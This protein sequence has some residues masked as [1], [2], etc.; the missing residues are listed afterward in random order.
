[1]FKVFLAEDE[2]V[3]REGL[4]NNIAWE[5]YGFTC[6]G[7]AADGEMALPLIRQLKPDLLITD[8]KMPFMDGLALSAFVRRELPDT[9]IIIISGYDDFKYAQQAISMGVDEYLLKPITRA[10]MAGILASLQK[11]LEDEREMKDYMLKFRQETQEYEQFARRRFF[12]KLVQGKLSAQEIYQGAE[13]LGIDITARS[14]NIVMLSLHDPEPAAAKSYADST[15]ELQEQL[16]QYVTCCDDFLLFRWN[17]TTYAILIKGEPEN[18]KEATER[19]VENLSRRCLDAKGAAWYVA[20]GSPVERLS[21]LPL[22]FSQASRILSYSYLCPERHI[23]TTDCIDELKTVVSTDMEDS[24]IDPEQ[25]RVF[26]ANGE[27]EEVDDFVSRLL[28]KVSDNVLNSFLFCQYLCITVCFAATGYIES[29]GGDPKKLPRPDISKPNNLNLSDTVREYLCAVLRCAL[30]LRQSEYS[31]RYRDMLRQALAFIDKNY[32]DDGLSLNRVAKEVN[33]SPNYFSAVFSQEVG[34]TFTEYLT[35]RRMDEAR[36]LLRGT[37][38]RSSEI[39][40]AVGYKD[41]HYFSFLF[42]K[43]QGCTPRDFRGG[44]A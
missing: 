21:A 28:S 40:E 41:P 36:R 3:V 25:I 33:I 13:A 8:I 1:M 15:A 31:K 14:Y 16:V 27:S 24:A 32:A 10:N 6:V 23:L 2:I 26:L 38:M 5:Q 39:A 42:K 12:E 20:A 30:E 34:E 22:C 18:I 17:L 37:T 9:H 29:I 19:C 11:K 35:A 4:R 44:K 7:D 43:T